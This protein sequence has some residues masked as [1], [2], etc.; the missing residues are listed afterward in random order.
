MKNQTHR[1]TIDDYTVTI[2]ADEAFYV[3]GAELGNKA[4]KGAIFDIEE[5]GRKPREGWKR[6]LIKDGHQQ[7]ENLYFGQGKKEKP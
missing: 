4:G 6:K 5:E 7:V 2:T 1:L 3:A